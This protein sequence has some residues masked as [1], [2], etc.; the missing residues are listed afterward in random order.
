MA[1]KIIKMTIKDYSEVFALWENS[2]GV[3]LHNDSDSK[4]SIYKYLN[5][6]PGLSFIARDKSLVVGAV[7]CGH[8]GRR[9]YLHHL[10]VAKSHRKKGLGKMLVQKSLSK[11]LNIGI[12]RCH[13]FVLGENI[14]AQK[15]W[16]KIGWLELK[17]LKIISKKLTRCCQCE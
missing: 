14:S 2:E 3:C 7:L 10:A 13:I 8:D 5:R 15:F 12:S 1:V 16:K 4:K 11:L 17:G 9:G 6:N